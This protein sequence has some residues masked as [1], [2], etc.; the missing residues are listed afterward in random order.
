MKRHPFDPFSFVAGS[1]CA[2]LALFFL[3]GERTAADLDADWIWPVLIL[4]PGLLLV[5]Y[6]LGRMTR[7]RGAE[8]PTPAEPPEPPEA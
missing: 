6:A 7:P 8:E 3:G 5:L 2:A 1:V 4:V